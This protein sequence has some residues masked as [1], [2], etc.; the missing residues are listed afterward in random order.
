MA[1]ND[2]KKCTCFYLCDDRQA[3]EGREKIPVFIAKRRRPSLPICLV[4]TFRRYILFSRARSS[5]SST[6]DCY[7]LLS[8]YDLP[9]LKVP[10]SHKWTSVFVSISPKS[11][12]FLGSR[13]W[14]TGILFVLHYRTLPFA[15]DPLPAFTLQASS[16]S[17]LSPCSSFLVPTWRCL[18]CDSHR[19]TRYIHR[20][21][22]VYSAC[23]ARLSNLPD[24]GSGSTCGGG[25]WGTSGDASWDSRASMKKKGG[26]NNMDAVRNSPLLIYDDEDGLC[27]FGLSFWNFEFGYLL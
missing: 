12:L 9:T 17:G 8:P 5:F 15:L 1:A 2:V 19:R 14:R 7:H 11:Q 25:G 22:H 21:L 18:E 24:L 10:C 3:E 4:T 16:G 27:W 6:F 26:Y 20:R 13:R 23:L